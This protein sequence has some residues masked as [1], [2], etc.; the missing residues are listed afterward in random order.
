M[1]LKLFVFVSVSLLCATAPAVRAQSSSPGS[2]TLTKVG[3]GAA[4][5]LKLGVGARAVGL[6][7]AYVAL[8][9]DLSSLYWNP[10]GLAG[11]Q[12]SA[13]Q[14]SHTQYLADV[15]YNFAAFGVNLGTSGTVAASITA[16]NSGTMD[17][18]TARRPEGTGEEFSV[19]NLAL[20]L[21][22]GR[23]LTD[24]FSIGGSAKYIREQI[25]HSSASAL[26]VDIGTLFTLPYERLKLGASFSNF[27][28]KMQMDGR[29][30]V[31]SQDPV[32]DEEGNVG[33]VNAE[34]LMEKSSL[35]LLFRVGLSWSALESANNRLTLL[36]DAAHPNDNSEYMNFGAEYSFRDLI[37]LRAGYRHLFETDS[38][39]GLTFGAGLNLRIDRSVRARIDYA[40]ADFGRLEQTHWFTL[41]LAF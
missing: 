12:G 17:V 5:F 18:R 37:D 10:A 23:M 11:L 38:E 6:G 25:W 26:A 15:D 3:T 13:V 34:Y 27:G 14:L 28:P 36:T 2:N 32:P 21:S 29:D 35:P 41:D 22:Y 7:G 24:R 16:L 40:Y 1:R 30:L 33:I 39:Q 20:Q 19:T 9:N 4:S 31:F 8:A